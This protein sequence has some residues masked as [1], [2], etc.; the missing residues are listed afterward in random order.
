MAYTYYINDLG[1]TKTLFDPEFGYPPTVPSGYF[2]IPKNQR[3]QYSN[4]VKKTQA[5]AAYEAE[6]NNSPSKSNL[7]STPHAHKLLM[8]KIENVIFDFR[9]RI[10]QK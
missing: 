1:V 9:G 4:I 6:A 3:T 2:Q 5:V 10:T 7:I 8:T